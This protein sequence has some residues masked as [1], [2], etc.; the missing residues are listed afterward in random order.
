MWT[1]DLAL[2]EM[3]TAQA[4]LAAAG[5]AFVLDDESFR[6]FYDRTSRP[7]WAYLWRVSGNRALADDLAQESYFRLLRA[8][9]TSGDD[10]YLKNYLFRIAANL[11]RDHWRRERSTGRSSPLDP[12]E[13]RT[14][15]AASPDLAREHQRRTDLAAML[16]SLKPRERQ[17]LWL[18]YVEGSSHREIAAAVG[19]REGSIRL[20]L[21]RARRRLAKL[22]RSEGILS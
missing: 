10:E 11:L 8:R 14:A 12:E 13:G 22:L 3:E 2:S 16:R 17:L 21:F 9:L 18:A 7:L 5:K 19:L 6:G 15:D 1:R 20:L 4:A